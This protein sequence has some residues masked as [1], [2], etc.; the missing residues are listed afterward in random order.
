MNGEQY[1]KMVEEITKRMSP[2]EKAISDKHRIIQELK[3]DIVILT[4]LTN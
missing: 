3:E 4:H 1:T 2:H